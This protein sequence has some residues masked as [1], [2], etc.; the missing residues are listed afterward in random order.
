MTHKIRMTRP[1]PRYTSA[2][3]SNERSLR[4]NAEKY[5]D[6]ADELESML[7]ATQRKFTEAFAAADAQVST[8]DRITKAARGNRRLGAVGN[9]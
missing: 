8:R 3:G 7:A 5:R 9:R 1:E 2:P 4:R 6:R